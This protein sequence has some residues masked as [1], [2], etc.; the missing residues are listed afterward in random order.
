MKQFAKNDRLD[1]VKLGTEPGTNYTSHSAEAFKP[2][3]LN[4]SAENS[5]TMKKKI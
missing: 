3:N 2:L 1:S 4:R 5:E